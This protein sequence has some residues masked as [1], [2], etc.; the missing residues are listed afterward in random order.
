MKNILKLLILLT[1]I[2]ICGCT[3]NNSMEDI[4]IYTT[5]YPIEYVVDR[6]YGEHSTIKSIYP[7]G[8][9]INTYEVTNILLN[10]YSNTDMFIFNGLNKER[11]YVKSMLKENDNLKIIDATDGLSYDYYIEELWLNPNKLL[12]IANNLKK[13]FN[14]YISNAYLKKEIETNYEELKKDLTSMDAKYRKAARESNSTIVVSSNMFLFLQKY[15]MNVISLQENN[16]SSAKDINTV[17]D[18]I[19]SGNLKYIYILKGETASDTINSL[20]NGTN[21]QLI[22]LHTLSNLDDDERDKY[23]YLTL[24]NENLELLKLQLYQ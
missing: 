22:E 18:L 5:T 11:N 20:I 9:D 12:S 23:D 10:E 3:N 15:G 14:E 13:G 19:N 2:P 8:I 7:N 21:I 1:I 24:I 6:L 17:K 4:T 16:S